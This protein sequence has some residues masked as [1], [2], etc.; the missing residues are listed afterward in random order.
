MKF[1]LSWLKDHLK[2]KATVDEIATRLSAIGLEVESVENPGAKLGA[3]RVARIVEATRAVLSDA[4]RQGGT[5]LR[6]YVN[7]DGTP[8][9]FRQELYVYERTGDE[10]PLRA[11]VN[12]GQ[13]LPYTPKAL[14]TGRNPEDIKAMAKDIG[15]RLVPVGVRF[16]LALI[17]V[18]AN[19]F[20]VQVIGIS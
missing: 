3:F 12:T 9:Y 14:T 7:A 18:Q 19:R 6:D 5:T 17:D 15:K 4:I 13:G 10:G 11:T 20:E 8:G 16:L 2:T 1:T